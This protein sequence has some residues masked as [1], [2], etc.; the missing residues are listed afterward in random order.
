MKNNNVRTFV[1]SQILIVLL[2]AKAVLVLQGE[3]VET[4]PS[5]TEAVVS[6][7]SHQCVFCHTMKTPSVVDQWRDSSHARSGVSC[8]ECH[9]A[10]EGEPDAQE[11]YGSLISALVTPKDCGACHETETAQFLDSHHAKGGEVLGSLDNYLG[12]VVEGFGANISGCQQC[13][14]SIVEVDEKGK[15]TADTWPNS[16]IGRVNP[17]G[18][19]GACSAC[20]SRHDFSVSQARTPET[21]GKCHLGPD[22]PQ[23]EVYEESKH[24]IAY[25]SHMNEMNMDKSQ[26]VVGVDYSAGPVCATCHVSATPNQARTHDIGGRLSWNIRAPVSKKTKNADQKRKAMQ[27][28]CMN[29]HNEGYVKNHYKQLDEGIGLYNEKFAKPAGEMVKALKE[30]GLLDSTPFNEEVDWTYFYLW[31]HEGRRARN[32]LA[33]MAPDYVQWHGFYDIAERFYMELIPQAEHL[34]PGIADEILERPE[35]KWFRGNLSDE[36]RKGI[37]E[38]YQK[39]YRQKGM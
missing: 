25:R 32:G 22:H 10:E 4:T 19:A 7:E 12:E 13:H 20:H 5:T 3:K 36:E 23:K 28:V 33:M 26:W 9:A 30:A 6:A 14:G 39:R 27:E 1:L 2:I 38:S 37:N 8:A 29:C 24:G 35:H 18:T 11:H 21:C 34:M 16:G 17:D 31:H 15:L